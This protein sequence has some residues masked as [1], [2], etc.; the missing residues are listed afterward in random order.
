[1]QFQLSFQFFNGAGF[2]THCFACLIVASYITFWN[3]KHLFCARRSLIA[4]LD[5]YAEK[6]WNLF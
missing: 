5:V 3:E 1:M 2:S 4:C 6:Y